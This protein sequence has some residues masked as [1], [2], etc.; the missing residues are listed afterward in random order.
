MRKII[1]DCDPG[2]DDSLALMLALASPELDIVGITTVSGNVEVNQATENACKVLDLMGRRDIPVYK[3]ASVPLVREFHD[4][5]DTHGMD[6]IGENYFEKAG[7]EIQETE[8]YRFILDTIRKNPGEITLLGLGPL[9]NIALAIREDKEA[10]RGVKELIVMGG[11]DKFHGNCSPVAEFNFWV[12]PHAAREV[13]DSCITPVVMVGLD[14]THEI[15]F[16]PNLREVVNQFGTTYAR[17]IHDITRFYVD[18]HWRQERTIGCVINDP[19]VIAMLIDP[20]IVGTHDA[21]VDIETEGIALAQSVCDAGGI[22]TKG[23]CNA[24]VADRVNPRR[25]FEIFLERI[26]PEFKD[27]IQ[28]AL[29]KQY[30][31]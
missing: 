17:F 3:G 24:R 11:T 7:I 20:E 8:A 18:F 13:F 16:T 15:I 26:F 22:W 10:M 12:D 30:W 14:V 9:T 25:F 23:V 1:I 21:Y 4:A 6:G 27:D 31:G 28:L 29:N 19:L 2:I 5:T